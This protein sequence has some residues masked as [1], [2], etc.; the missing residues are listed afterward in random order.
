MKGR[1]FFVFASRRRSDPFKTIIT[2]GKAKT[3]HTGLLRY[4]RKD[5][6]RARQSSFLCKAF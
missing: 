1:C 4:A 3:K 6:V 5:E 2:T